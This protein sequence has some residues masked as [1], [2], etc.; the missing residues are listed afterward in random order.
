MSIE[1]IPVEILYKVFDTLYDEINVKNLALTTKFL[2]YVFINFKSTKR[3]SYECPYCIKHTTPYLKS[4]HY[5]MRA[6]CIKRF[7][8]N[9]T[10]IF[11]NRRK[12]YA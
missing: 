8:K 6:T 10:K 11:Y 1:N 2:Y 7:V 3:L 9:S 4:I 12:V 5:H